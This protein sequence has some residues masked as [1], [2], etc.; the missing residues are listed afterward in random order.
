M[1]ESDGDQVSVYSVGREAVH[2]PEVQVDWL[3]GDEPA[4][5]DQPRPVFLVNIVQK[6]GLVGP[7]G[8][9]GFKYKRGLWFPDADGQDKLCYLHLERWNRTCP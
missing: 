5:S 1:L 8:F 7:S 3:T 6:F 4:S 9:N 2:Q